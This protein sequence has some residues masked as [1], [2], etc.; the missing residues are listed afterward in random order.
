M[1]VRFL[2]RVEDARDEPR[3]NVLVEEVAHRVH[4]YAAG[5]LPQTRLLQ[6]F[7][8]EPQVEPELEGVSLNTTKAFRKPLGVAVVATA[9][10]LRAARHGIPGCVGPLDA[11]VVRHSC[12]PFRFVREGPLTRP[13]DDSIDCDDLP[14][15][16]HALAA[17]RDWLVRIVLRMQHPLPV[18]SPQSFNRGFPFQPSNDDV[19]ALGGFLVTCDHEIARHDARTNH[20]VPHNTE[21]I[22][23]RTVSIGGPKGQLPIVMLLCQ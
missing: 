5:P 7:R 4:E 1:P 22:E 16:S 18:S 10:D 12:A 15:D 6:A 11:A 3:W 23:R 13:R 9:A 14:L 21:C 8:P 17:N 20:A 19:A 2:H